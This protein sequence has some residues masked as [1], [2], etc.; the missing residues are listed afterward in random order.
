MTLPLSTLPLA[1]T[2][3]GVVPVLVEECARTDALCERLGARLDALE[4]SLR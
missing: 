1:L 3:D 4:L 2:L